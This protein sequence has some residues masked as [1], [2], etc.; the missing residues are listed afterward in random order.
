MK[1]PKW[2]ILK[3]Y[4]KKREG[5]QVPHGTRALSHNYLKLDYKGNTFRVN[6]KI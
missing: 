4:I 6:F 5:D 3:N 2:K 1:K